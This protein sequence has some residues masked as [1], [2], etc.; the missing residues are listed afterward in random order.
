MRLPSLTLLL[1]TTSA[2]MLQA[3]TD[4]RA[5]LAEAMK[6][7][8][9]AAI[10]SA[11]ELGRQALGN[12]AGEPEVA[13]EHQ[14]VPADAKPLTKD[15]AQRGMAP[16]LKRLE[17]LRW[18]KIGVD[19]TKLTA[20]L[21]APGSVI[22]G[23]VAVAK[24]KLDGADQCLGFAKDAADFLIWA[25]DQAGAGCFPFPAAKGTSDARAMQVATRFLANAEKAGKL[26]ETVRNGWAYNDHGDGGLQFDN[27]E[28]GVAMFE[29]Y[30]LTKDPRYLNS[31]IKAADW[32][33]ALPLCTNWNYNAFSVHL[34]AKAYAVTH[35]AKYLQSS[36]QKALLGVIPGQ[37][38]D[39]PHA[40]RWLDP[41]NAR[42]AYHYV[43]M[44]ALAQ[45]AAAMPADHPDR[46]AVMKSLTLGLKSRNAEFQTLGVMTKDK[47]I[48]T[49]LLTQ[50]LFA[51]DEAF[52]TTTQTTEALH[53]LAALA[54]EQARRGKLPFGPRGWGMM[55]GWLATA[56][57]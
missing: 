9:A 31:A 50:S 45:L 14:P 16:H 44:G 1:F 39:G 47:A 26:D 42:P 48:E 4:P 17:Q 29:L 23:M 13:D 10:R 33:A 36:L 11:V 51:N 6:T 24:A 34:L 37:L 40:G 46:T 41:H 18:W 53:T 25:Q 22:G 32:A 35:D 21:R 27:G 52:L 57:P 54:S 12:K 43:M 8:D 28:C 2:L 49:L 56:K 15:E 55:L 19:P 3:Q 38:T 5:A 30:E 7:Q 20:P